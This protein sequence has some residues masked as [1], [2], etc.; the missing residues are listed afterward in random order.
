V[1]RVKDIAKQ[2]GVKMPTVSSVLKT[3]NNREL[4]NY[5][6]YEY[7]ELTKDGVVVGKEMR[8][9]HE[10]LFKFLTEILQIES[11]IAEKEACKMDE[12]KN[13]IINAL[14]SNAGELQRRMETHFRLVCSLSKEQLD[15]Q[16]LASQAMPCMGQ[17]LEA[18]YRNAIK[19]AIEVIE[20]TRKAFKSKRLEVLRKKLT[21]I[22]IE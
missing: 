8:R 17:S 20:E 5:E 19:E 4:V 18:K 15:V 3:L 10:L 7:V 9:R 21:Q 6:N 22:L 1:V 16:D 11:P 13:E 2:M 14:V 12:N